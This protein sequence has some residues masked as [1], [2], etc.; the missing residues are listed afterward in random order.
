MAY[1]YLYSVCDHC[2]KQ[3]TDNT[4]GRPS[5]YCSA[6]CK[7]RAYRRRKDNAKLEE[8]IAQAQHALKVYEEL[9]AK[10]GLS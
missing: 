5:L 3:Y 10:H 7:Q 6:K 1:G 2:G 8:T 9:R 4:H